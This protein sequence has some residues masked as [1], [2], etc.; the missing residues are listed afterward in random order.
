MKK[1]WTLFSWTADYSNNFDL[2]NLSQARPN[3]PP[4]IFLT[5]VLIETQ[6]L[7]KAQ[8][9]AALPAVATMIYVETF[10]LFSVIT[11]PTQLL[12]TE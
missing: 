7:G 8:A 10:I 6:N 12:T 4:Q 1:L 5:R 11:Y 2:A 3:I 9:L